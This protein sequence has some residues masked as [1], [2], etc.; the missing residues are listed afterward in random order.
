MRMDKRCTKWTE[1]RKAKMRELKKAQYQNPELRKKVG[2]AQKKRFATG[3]HP[4]L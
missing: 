1:E 2:L 4:R 3:L